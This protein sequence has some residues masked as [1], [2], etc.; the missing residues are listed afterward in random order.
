M[1]M[2][3]PH[4]RK[5]AIASL[6]S[7]TSSRHDSVG[8]LFAYF[9]SRLAEWSDLHAGD[10]VLDVAAGTGRSLVPAAAAVGEAGHV[11]GTDLAPGMVELLQQT[12]RDHA[13][14]NAHALVA[15]AE[16][17]P[18]D[19]A[20][21][22]AVL[23]GF[24]LFFFPDPGRALAEFRRVLRAGGVVAT[25]TFT[26]TGSASMDLTWQL[27]GKH[28]AVPPPAADD[29]RFHDADQLRSAFRAARFSNIEIEVSPFEM[30]LPDV[31]AWLDW[32]RSMEFGEYLD[33]LS[34][35]DVEQLKTAAGT[36]LGGSAASRE[37]RFPMDA[38]LTRARRP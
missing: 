36:V 34:R 24:G 26:R 2:T 10:Q 9:G 12:I 15:D 23:C 4:T 1:G 5:E 21:F 13:L 22:D 16:Q 35:D 18:F 17:L 30:V 8:G 3:G 32:L 7:T 31:E 11:T 28:I 37:I 29:T 25:S 27:I 38:F 19:D 6:F 33:R 20:T 14:D